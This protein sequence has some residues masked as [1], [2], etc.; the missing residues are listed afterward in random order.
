VAWEK[1]IIIIMIITETATEIIQGQ[2]SL[3][4]FVSSYFLLFINSVLYAPLGS[5]ILSSVAL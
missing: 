2:K 4:S 1:I 5:E 3:S